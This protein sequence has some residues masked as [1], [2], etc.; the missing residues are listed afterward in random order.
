MLGLH[1]YA[2]FSL[3]VASSGYSPAG[4][5]GLLIVVA[6]LVAECGLE[7]T[8]LVVV[9]P[10]SL[11]APWR[12]GFFPDEGWNL[13]LLHWQADSLPRSHQGNPILAVL[14]TILAIFKCTV[15]WNQVHSHSCAPL[16][17]IHLQDFFIFPN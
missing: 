12:V 6:S 1:C 9:M 2:G 17:N 7:G 4:V 11:V 15:G 10:R 3:A 5:C 14:N 13:C 16:T 8:G